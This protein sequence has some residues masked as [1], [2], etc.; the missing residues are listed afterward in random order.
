MTTPSLSQP[1][2]LIRFGKAPPALAC[3]IRPN[4]AETGFVCD[5]MV[6]EMNSTTG[7]PQWRKRLADPISVT[8][9]DILYVFRG[10][11]NRFDVA[12]ARRALRD[13]VAS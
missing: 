4:T 10:K 1:W 11:P 2:V 6:T 9:D 3:L 13:G 7:M 8:Y 5:V 12:E